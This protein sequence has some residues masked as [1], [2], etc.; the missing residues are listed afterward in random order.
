[1]PIKNFVSDIHDIQKQLESH[2]Y[3]STAPLHRLYYNKY[4]SSTT[5]IV[6]YRIADKKRQSRN[7]LTVLG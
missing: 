3:P 2:I 4:G 7:C 6:R 5:I 1:M